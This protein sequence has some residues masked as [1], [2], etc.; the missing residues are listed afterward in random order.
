MPAAAS[1]RPGRGLRRWLTACRSISI[2]PLFRH[3]DR[4]RAIV[5][6]PPAGEF[7][8]AVPG[9]FDHRIL[10]ALAHHVVTLPARLPL[11]SARRQ[12]ARR[13]AALRQ[14][15]GDDAAR[16][17]LARRGL[18]FSGLGWP[19]RYLSLHQ[20]SLARLA[21]WQSG[22]IAN[23]TGGERRLLGDHL[24]CRR[25]RLGVLPRPNG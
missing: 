2:S 14:F 21:R 20:S 23:R 24:L 4:A 15:A 25:A 9:H 16:R 22:R 12:S 7:S 5:R 6:H 8:L 3:G 11:H 19:A 13:T 17:A 1:P 10:A 18:E